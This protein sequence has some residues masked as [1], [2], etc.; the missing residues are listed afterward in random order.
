M[1]PLFGHRLLMLGTLDN[2]RFRLLLRTLPGKA[3]DYLYTHYYEGLILLSTKYLH[4]RHLAEDIVQ[5]T[6]LHVWEHHKSLSRTHDLPIQFYLTRVVKNKS[7]TQ[8]KK[9]LRLQENYGQ[10]LSGNFL[11]TTDLNAET[12]II[13]QEI[14]D[15]IKAKINA[16]PMREKECLKMKIEFLMTT[17]EI[18]NELGVTIKAVERSLTSAHKRLRKW[19]RNEF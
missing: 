17:K 15:R 13:H 6:F 3:I 8:Y 18:A 19:A 14:T 4:D 16:F 2:E 12:Q 5:E 1:L 9:G 11:A 7:I 10:F